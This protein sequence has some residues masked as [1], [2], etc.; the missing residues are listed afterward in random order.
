MASRFN[1]LASSGDG[2]SQVLEDAAPIGC[3]TL[4]IGET[5]AVA[6]PHILFII[7][8]LVEMGGAERSL[9]RM[10]RLLPRELFRCSILTFKINPEAPDLKDVSCPLYVWP[11][12]KTYGWSGIKVAARIR[13]FIREENVSIVHTFFETSDLWAGPIAR[14]SGCPVWV[15]SRRDLGI[16]RSF[17]HRVGYK[18]LGGLSDAVLA[19]SPQVRDFCIRE[20]RL[21]PVKVRT[22]FNG[23]EMERISRS[24]S[25]AAMRQQMGIAEN[26]PVITT[27]GNIRRVKGI[28]VFVRA[29]AVVCRKHPQALFLIV[30]RRS[31]EEYC[32]E[33]EATIQAQG[34][35]S[36]F[37]LLGSSE[38]VFS[39]L[40]MS[41]VFCLPSRSEGFSNALLE[42]MACRLPCVATDVGG[43][44]EVLQHGD[45][46]LLVASE[47]WNDLAR[48]LLFLLDDP[49]LATEMGLRGEEL[50]RSQFTADIMMKNLVNVYQELLEARSH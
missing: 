17:K 29:A 25:R 37:R 48:R 34:L 3:K 42:A 35:H 4:H 27:V 16:L 46:G 8:E 19:V 41:D 28:D 38:D 31:E 32:R 40:R 26:V 14:L 47:D 44:G 50:I 11:V 24:S 39:I 18:F 45:T 21:S 1:N 33:L 12:K 30:G 10:A 36:N 9:F 2:S 6:R 20:D 5:E 22:L 23:I 15:S 43:N 7:D 49:A 13:R